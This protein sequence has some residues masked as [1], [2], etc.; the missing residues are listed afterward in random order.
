M[1]LTRLRK[2]KLKNDVNQ[3]EYKLSNLQIT[4]NDKSC[5]FDKKRNMI[6]CID[7][8]KLKSSIYWSDRMNIVLNKHNEI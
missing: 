5:F 7:N 8:K 2:K 3:C 6:L 4:D 1:P